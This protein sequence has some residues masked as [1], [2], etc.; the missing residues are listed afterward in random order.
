VCISCKKEKKTRSK[1]GH[2][3]RERAL[4]SDISMIG[5]NSIFLN[6]MQR[7]PN[8]NRPS[9]ALYKHEKK[10][11]HFTKRKN[12][13]QQLCKRSRD[14][15]ILNEKKNCGLWAMKVII[16][17]ERSLLAM[18]SFFLV[19]PITWARYLQQNPTPNHNNWMIQLCCW[20]I[21]T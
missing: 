15:W 5:P 18:T 6:K 17:F 11:S 7:S 9:I 1:T 14:A 2:N 8:S 4:H 20:Y 16:F 10:L 19:M 12:G 3:I 13:E 21:I